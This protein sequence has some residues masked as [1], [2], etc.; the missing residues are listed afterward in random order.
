MKEPLQ[1]KHIV[2]TAILAM[3]CTL[4]ITSILYVSLKPDYLYIVFYKTECVKENVTET[5]QEEFVCAYFRL[6]TKYN[7]TLKVNDFSILYDG[8]YKEASKVEYFDQ[9]ISTV[10]YTYPNQPILKV[11]YRVPHTEAEGVVFVKYKDSVMRIGELTI[12]K[13]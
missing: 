7:H 11:Y 5:Y 1:K 3:L 2:L 12:E 10:F 6:N 13:V 4:L 9:S 8:K